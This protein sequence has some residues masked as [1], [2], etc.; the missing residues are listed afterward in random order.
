MAERGGAW[1]AASLL[2]AFFVFEWAENKSVV[3]AATNQSSAANSNA[4]LNSL[5]GAVSKLIQGAKSGGGGIGSSG[6][7][8]SGGSQSGGSIA[9]GPSGSGFNPSTFAPNQQASLD[10]APADTSTIAPEQGPG[11]FQV[12]S[13]DYDPGDNSGFTTEDGTSYD[14]D[15]SSWDS[16]DSGL[17]DDV[18]YGDDGSGDYSDDSFDD[19]FGDDF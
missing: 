7:S 13:M 3:N 4:G 16:I 17:A 19:G 6:G 11:D 12:A 1:I 15:G 10:P 18:A 14:G 5:L 8:G 9:Q 2:G